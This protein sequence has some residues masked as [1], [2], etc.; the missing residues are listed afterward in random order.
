[1][2]VSASL[3]GGSLAALPPAFD[4]RESPISGSPSPEGAL[5]FQDV[6][7]QSL[8]QVNS[9]D[10]ESQSAVAAGLTGG[11]L[12]QAEI[13]TAMKKADLAFRTMLQIRNK[14]VEAYNEVKNMR[15]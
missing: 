6:L 15:M 5:S 12:T 11:D 10:R 8:E 13:F 14:L 3:P 1:M 4:T 9:L 7:L 2:P